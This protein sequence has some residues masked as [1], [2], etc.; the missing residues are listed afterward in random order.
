MDSKFLGQCDGTGLTPSHHPS[1]TRGTQET[2]F[3]ITGKNTMFKFQVFVDLLWPL[4]LIKE[5]S[6]GPVWGFFSVLYICIYIYTHTQIHTKTS[7]QLHVY[8]IDLGA[9]RRHICI[10]WLIFLQQEGERDK[11][12]PEGGWKE[13]SEWPP[14]NIHSSERQ[15]NQKHREKSAFNE[16]IKKETKLGQGEVFLVLSVQEYDTHMHK[17]TQAG[18][19]QDCHPRGTRAERGPG[20][21]PPSVPLRARGR[22]ARHCGSPFPK[23]K[24]DQTHPPNIHTLTKKI[25]I[26]SPPNLSDPISGDGVHGTLGKARGRMNPPPVPQPSAARRGGCLHLLPPAKKIWDGDGDAA[27]RWGRKLKI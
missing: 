5:E 16:A 12:P 9:A 19:C 7:T 14:Q 13:P 20:A 25:V 21:L 15:W 18:H 2:S 11:T 8:R 24:T 10:C 6:L 1:S 3:P 27:R 17:L 4:L 23:G 22:S 26:I